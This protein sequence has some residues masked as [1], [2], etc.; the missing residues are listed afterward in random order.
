MSGFPGCQHLTIGQLD[1]RH[2]PLAVVLIRH[3]RDGHTEES[4]PAR[5][6]G[7]KAT[8]QG[9]VEIL[10]LE[11]VNP[12]VCRAIVGG[13][14]LKPGLEIRIL[15]RNGRPSD[16]TAEITAVGEGSVRDVTFNL[17]V[18][19]F[20]GKFTPFLFIGNISQKNRLTILFKPFLK[21]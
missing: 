13:K 5:L 7:R 12:N 9:K 10:I 20:L 21:T 11:L 1:K 15:D 2:V 18:E 14:R 3:G 19:V 17:P 6:F 16:I 8:T 4:V